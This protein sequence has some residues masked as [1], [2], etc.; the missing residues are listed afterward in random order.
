MGY[1]FGVS[2]L[3]SYFYGGNSREKLRKLRNISLF[4][5]GL[6]A[7]VT[8]ICAVAGS[9]S[10]V[11][12]FAH[13]GTEAYLLAIRGN[14]LFSAALLLVG[15]NTFSSMLF[16]ALSNGLISAVISFSRT[17]LFLIGAVVTLPVLWGLDGLWLA[18]PVSE[19]MAAVLSFFFFEKYKKKYGY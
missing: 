10:L 17:F 16:T 5:I 9:E 7:A 11:G 14:K 12:I 4:F 18:V 6:V 1:M 3:L 2:P 8:T 19:L 15:F 13:P